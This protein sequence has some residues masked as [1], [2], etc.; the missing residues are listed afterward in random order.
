MNMWS[1]KWPASPAC[2][3]ATVEVKVDDLHRKLDQLLERS[4]GGSCPMCGICTQHSRQQEATASQLSAQ[5]KLLEN[6]ERKV[7]DLRNALEDLALGRLARI[8][9]ILQYNILA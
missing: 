2:D 6:L 4:S 8:Y 5:S 3:P 9:I 7:M 1:V